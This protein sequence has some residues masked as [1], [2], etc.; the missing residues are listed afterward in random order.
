M[1]ITP[2]HS[3]GD[4][5]PVA[6]RQFTDR[7]DFIA[8]FL[9]ALN[10][11][12]GPEPHVLVYYG[13]GG[14]GKTSLRRQLYKL[15]EGK[16]GIVSAALDFDV[17]SYRDPETALFALR[18]D[19]QQRFKCHFPTFDVA[20][21]VY[22][23]KTRPQT[24]LTKENFAL[25]EDSV[26]LADIVHI[27]GAVPIVGTISRLSVLAVKGGV[28][29]KDWWDRRGHT[30]LK[31]LAGMEPLEIAD[32]LPMFWASD[33]KDFL[34]QKQRSAVLFLDTYEV[35]TEGERAEGKLRERDAWVRELVAQLPGALWVICGR[36]QLA[37]EK[38]DPEW[39]TALDQHLIGG[40]AEKDA[41]QFLRSCGIADPAIQQAIVDGSQGVP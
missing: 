34:E 40:L 6:A 31:G 4:K 2:K 33:L 18:K 39:G 28:L 41:R 24:P 22:W 3:L 7:E 11:P 8:A 23:Q 26:H 29:L 37:W 12:R 20:Y 25:L 9:N 19:L 38:A 17:A 15:T 14:I 5:R 30:E 32:R 13:V 35:L 16:E 1:P 27:A 10:A 36:E 21:A